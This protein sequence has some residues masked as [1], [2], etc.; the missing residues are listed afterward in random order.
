[1][2][3]HSLLDPGRGQAVV[4]FM[5]AAFSTYLRMIKFSH[6][7]F[8]LPF[9]GIAFL[10]ALPE[11][12]LWQGGPTPRFA[13]V[14]V[15]VLICMVSL[16]SAAMGFNR[17][18]DRTFD[19][20]NPRTKNREIPSGA[21]S[22][23]SVRWFVGLS[24]LV[25]AAAATM[26]SPLCGIL[27]P[28]AAALV[29]AYSYTKRFTWLC[30]FVLGLAIGQSPAATAIAMTGSLPA[31]SL[32]FSGGLALYI[33]GFDILYSC[34][35]VEFDRNRGLFSL[36][37]RFSIPAALWTARLS[38]AGALVLFFLAG[39]QAGLGLI[40]FAFLC[41]VLVLFFIEHWLVRPGHL[42]NIPMAFFHINASISSIL[43]AGLALDVWL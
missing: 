42:H 11:S 12:G 24:L 15:L 19:A 10:L 30:H 18:V 41:A 13:W 22:T 4:F 31:W 23:G 37:A 28:V 7:I 3:R 26:I 40:F 29:L 32:F 38:H 17:I 9:A 35:D 43:F 34:Q 36:P 6:T 33:A 5:L 14:L 2:S 16:R 8:A 1:M 20:E 27:S 39:S 21:L 25:F